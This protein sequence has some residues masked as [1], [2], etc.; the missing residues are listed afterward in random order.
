VDSP[1]VNMP[2]FPMPVIRL[3]MDMEQGSGQHPYGCPTQDHQPK[4]TEHVT[5][6]PHDA[7]RLAQFLQSQQ[8]RESQFYMA[9]PK[10]I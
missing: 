1:A 8:L 4:P 7:L 3:R 9:Q 2:D 6:R 10:R 5:N